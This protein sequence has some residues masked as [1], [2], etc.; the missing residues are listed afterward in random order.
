MDNQKISS[1]L[2]IRDS[3]DRDLALLEILGEPEPEDSLDDL[4]ALLNHIDGA[5]EKTC[6]LIEMYKH[7]AGTNSGRAVE[8][9]KSAAL[10]A[11]KADEYWQK[12]E[13]LSKIGFQCA[14]EG[15][16]D[17]ARSYW[18]QGAAIAANCQTVGGLQDSFD[19]SS[20]LGEIAINFSNVKMDEMAVKFATMIQN[21]A[22]RTRTLKMIS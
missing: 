21:E 1:I 2:N 9:L 18:E 4:E 6:G 5:Y 19:C 15:E 8:F 12:A 17:L 16:I 7:W 20:V 10:I 13:L 11:V 3:E 22:I 14:K